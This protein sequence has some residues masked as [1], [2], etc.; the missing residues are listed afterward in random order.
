MTNST[1]TKSE[2][3]TDRKVTISQNDL[4]IYCPSS[5]S[6]LWAEHPKVYLQLDSSKQATCPYCNTK[7]V[8]KD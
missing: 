1:I 7:Y 3:I 6:S 2:N 5:E 8:L 4:P